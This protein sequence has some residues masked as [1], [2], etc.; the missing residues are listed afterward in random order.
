[1]CATIQLNDG[2]FLD[3][4]YVGYGGAISGDVHPFSGTPGALGKDDLGFGFG[5]ATEPGGQ[6][7]NGPRGC[8]VISAAPS[9][10]RASALSTR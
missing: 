1:L 9:M 2:Q 8:R 3:R 5:A 10:C 6:F 7:A 4:S